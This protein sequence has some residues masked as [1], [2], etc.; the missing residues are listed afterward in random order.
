MRIWNLCLLDVDCQKGKSV[1]LSVC[2]EVDAYKS[3]N[4][5]FYRIAKRWTNYRKNTRNDLAA[6]LF[7]IARTQHRISGFT[8]EDSIKKEQ[9]LQQVVVGL[10]PRNNGE[11]IGKM[12]NHPLVKAM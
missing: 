6:S 9:I 1:M 11:I 10:P 4:F 7:A 12:N 8:I 5:T 2:E 3:L